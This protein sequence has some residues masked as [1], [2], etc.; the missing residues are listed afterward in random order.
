MALA[1]ELGWTSTLHKDLDG[2]SR[3]FEAS[4]PEV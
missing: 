3:V 1:Q 2:I 4:R